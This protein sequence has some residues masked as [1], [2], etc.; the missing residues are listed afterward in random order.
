MECVAAHETA[1][2][3]CALAP[4]LHPYMPIKHAAAR[5]PVCHGPHKAA[6]RDQYACRG[7]GGALLERGEP[8]PPPPLR[9]WLSRSRGFIDDL[10]PLLL[11]RPGVSFWKRRE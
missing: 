1:R 6:E 7:V 3:L 5:A 10:R 8:G 2:L 9:N 11:R 4:T